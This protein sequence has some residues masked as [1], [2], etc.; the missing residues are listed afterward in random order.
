MYISLASCYS[1]KTS[2]NTS[3]IVLYSSIPSRITAKTDFFCTVGIVDDSIPFHTPIRL[4]I[5]IS[6]TK[7]AIPFHSLPPPPG[8][9]L[10][11]KNVTSKHSGEGRIFLGT[12]KS[13]KIMVF[14]GQIDK[15]SWSYLDDEAVQKCLLVRRVLFRFDKMPIISSLLVD[16]KYINIGDKYS[17]LFPK[18]SF[19]DSVLKSFLIHSSFSRVFQSCTISQLIPLL[20][21]PKSLESMYESM[22][23]APSRGLFEEI[24]QKS[25][26][27]QDLTLRTIPDPIVISSSYPFSLTPPIISTC[28]SFFHPLSFGAVSPIPYMP[29]SATN[30]PIPTCTLVGKIVG[31]R[32]VSEAI[33]SV[34]SSIPAGKSDQDDSRKYSKSI[35]NIVKRRFL[36]FDDGTSLPSLCIRPH[37]IEYPLWKLWCDRDQDKWLNHNAI[38][39]GILGEV[40]A[41]LLAEKDKE[42][43][44]KLGKRRTLA[45]SDSLFS[46]DSSSMTIPSFS[47]SPRAASEAGVTFDSGDQKG[48]YH[49]VEN[50]TTTQENP[51]DATETH[52]NASWN[53]TS[54]SSG[55][56]KEC[57]IGCNGE[58]YDLFEEVFS[59]KSH[60]FSFHPIPEAPR[61]M[62]QLSR[63]PHDRMVGNSL[64]HPL[65]SPSNR[66]CGSISGCVG[67]CVDDE[68]LCCGNI[69]GTCDFLAN[70][71]KK[72]EY[73][74]AIEKEM[75]LDEKHRIKQRLARQKRRI[76]ESERYRVD[77]ELEEGGEKTSVETQSSSQPSQPLHALSHLFQISGVETQFVNSAILFQQSLSSLQ[78]YFSHENVARRNPSQTS[79][80][81]K[82]LARQKRRID[83]SERYRVD[84]EL[85]EGGEKT[86]VETQSSSQPSQPL[87][88]LSHLFQI[89]G[90]ETQFVNSAILFQQSLSSLQQYFSHENV[91][92]RNPSQKEMELDEKH[93]IKQRLAR[94]KRRIDESERYRVD[95]ELEEGGEKTS[96]ETQSSSQPSQPLHAL[97][98]LFQ[99]SGVETQFVNSAILFQQSLS[100]LQQYFSHENVARRNPS[101]TS[102]LIK[103]L[104]SIPPLVHTNN[105][106][107]PICGVRIYTSLRMTRHSRIR[108]L[109]SCVSDAVC[110]YGKLKEY[111]EMEDWIDGSGFVELLG[112]GKDSSTAP[113]F[114]SSTF[115]SISSVRSFTLSQ[116]TEAVPCIKVTPVSACTFAK[117]SQGGQNVRMMAR[118]WVEDCT[119]CCLCLLE[120][121]H[122]CILYGL[123]ESFIEKLQ[124]SCRRRGFS[125]EESIE[126]YNKVC[127]GLK[128]A[129]KFFVMR[130][131]CHKM[132]G[133]IE[134]V[135]LF[136]EPELSE[137]GE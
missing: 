93:R 85:E 135:S 39:L 49:F 94:Q 9:V 30:A 123:P 68:G 90:V 57:V 66:V 130:G 98:H 48:E 20:S 24:F 2:L 18:Y 74:A 61:T 75:E 35:P 124:D 44:M 104:A 97:S 12:T 114:S 132:I 67:I 60:D 26:E 22:V 137:R 86:S 109:G 69:G 133:I 53:D 107:L 31:Y 95:E 21:I 122:I 112:V 29:S 19:S 83:E 36:F 71:D 7:D 111:E 89:S 41:E 118:V 99:I 14:P 45:R 56:P 52:A 82:V 134:S 113:S 81:I 55:I 51:L 101:Q 62:S 27:S 50:A 105:G 121:R 59:Y 47:A 106:L 91:A 3:G 6:P 64:V 79:H 128:Y 37:R 102:H 33:P 54:S 4:S 88:A 115:L 65:L 17:T 43:E 10:L 126:A 76:D 25:E 87:H 40:S 78:Q 110:A 46:G 100:S 42:E 5:F 63:Y 131:R 32:V 34:D 92:R 116:P 72:K 108:A 58:C 127:R 84:E 77:E 11:L 15:S 119:G 120:P 103:V 80:L 13:S 1:A 23:L 38:V 70:M 96:V 117:I 8:S 136:S 129:N 125:L 73:V 16:K 28:P